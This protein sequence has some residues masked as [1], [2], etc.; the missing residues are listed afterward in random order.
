MS[1][2]CTKQGF[3]APPGVDQAIT[4]KVGSFAPD[5]HFLIEPTGDAEDLLGRAVHVTSAGGW[6]IADERAPGCD[7][8]V[9]RSAADYEKSYRMALG[10]LTA[11]SGGYGELLK[12]EARYGRSVEAEMKI[13]NLETL[14]AD[15]E[16]DC[17]EV[18]VKSVRIGTG[19]RKLL[20]KA[21]GVA[22]V[23]VGKGPI[24]VS[25]G[26]EAATDAADEIRWSTPQAY[27]FTYEGG[28]RRK[29]FELE[30]QIPGTLRN[31]ETFELVFTGSE[32]AYLVIYY[33]EENGEGTVLFPDAGVPVPMFAAGETLSLP[34]AGQKKLQAQLRDPTIPERGTVVVYAFAERGD[35]DRFRPAA[36]T[37]STD[38]LAYAAELTRVLS[39]V[40]I[41]RWDR[42]TTTI[43]ILPNAE[44]SKP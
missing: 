22:K 38:A 5:M 1:A 42:H 43:E 16:G 29:V 14:T 30:A 21:E 37:D 33:L 15:I 24:G 10:D 27:A 31:G 2:A 19:E 4:A 36:L 35:F 20:R 17:G 40:P 8:R 26:R 11:L 3:L 28:V 6:T 12:L 32:D 13:H 44:T 23:N 9:K 34:P 25:A 39:S 18:I 41:S 7:V